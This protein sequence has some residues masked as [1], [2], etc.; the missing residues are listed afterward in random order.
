MFRHLVLILCLIGI[1]SAS[2]QS[3][4]KFEDLRSVFEEGLVF[5]SV[6]QH[7]YTDSYTQ[8]TTG[9]DGIVWIDQV[10]YKLASE[11]KTIVVDGVTST[12]YEANRNRVI[13]SEYDEEADDFAPSRMLS[14]LD[15]TYTAREERMDGGWTKIILETEDEFAAYLVIEIEVDDELIPQR[16]TAYDFA[17]N[18][19]VTTFSNGR[20]VDRDEELFTLSYPEDA[21]IVD[22]RN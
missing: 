1:H 9:S 10:E 6:F 8:E 2:I 14:G 17:E 19:T 16:I 12:V 7:T 5:T 11:D 13:I 18:V 15:E 21:E 20:F 3:Q 4:E 22:L